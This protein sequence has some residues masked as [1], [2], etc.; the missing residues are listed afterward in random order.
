MMFNYKVIKKILAAFVLLGLPYIIFLT[1]IEPT[2]SNMEKLIFTF[3]YLVALPSI[4]FGIY[5]G[6]KFLLR[7][8]SKR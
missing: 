6:L 4:S 7:D 8:D 1:W 3:I 5:R 2:Y